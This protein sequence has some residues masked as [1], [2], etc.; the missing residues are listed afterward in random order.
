MRVR[1]FGEP[2]GVVEECDGRCAK[3]GGHR[4]RGDVFAAKNAQ[5]LNGLIWQWKLLSRL[6]LIGRKCCHEP[7]RSSKRLG[8][9]KNYSIGLKFDGAVS[10]LQAAHGQL[11]LRPAQQPGPA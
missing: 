11:G 7:V 9:V 10:R 4:A 6:C 8:S 3:G 1:L 2:I 5:G